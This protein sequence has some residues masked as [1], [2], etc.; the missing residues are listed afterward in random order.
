M[1]VLQGKV[2]NDWLALRNSLYTFYAANGYYDLTSPEW[3]DAMARVD[4]YCVK[5]GVSRHDYT[6]DMWAGV[7]FTKAEHIAG[8]IK[9]YRQQIG[10]IP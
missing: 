10:L 6:F 9:A 1:I 5:A 3:I 4:A 8:S 7:V 2:K